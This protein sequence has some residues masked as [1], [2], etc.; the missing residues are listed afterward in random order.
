MAMFVHL[1][2]VY[3]HFHTRVVALIS[4]NRNIWLAKPHILTLWLF[5]RK[6]LLGLPGGPVAKTPS[7][8]CRGP[9]FDPWSENLNPHATT[10]IEDPT[11]KPNK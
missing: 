9:R 10:K 3:R 8:Q 7:F 6:S 11:M 5:Y 4:C 2:V 1:S